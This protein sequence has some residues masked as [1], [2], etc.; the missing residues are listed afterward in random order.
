MKQEMLIFT[1]LPYA[2]KTTLRNKLV[3]EYGYSSVSV[4]EEIDRRG[5]DTEVMDQSQWDEVYSAAYK[6]LNSQLSE[7]KAVIVDIGN[8]KRSERDTTRKIAKE[9]WVSAKLIHINT[10]VDEIKRRQQ[11]NQETKHRGHLSDDLLNRAFS[12]FE[13][14]AIDENPITYNSQM[15][16]VDWARVN[17]EGVSSGGEVKNPPVSIK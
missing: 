4:D 3:E 9:H 8:L 15:D 17:I 10:S 1:G 16:F 5:Y 12:M 13:E 2:G 6:S 7:G 11:E 14:P